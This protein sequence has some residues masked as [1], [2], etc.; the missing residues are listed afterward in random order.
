[1]NWRWSHG[2]PP[3]SVSSRCDS[4][5]VRRSPCFSINHQLKTETLRQ[6]LNRPLAPALSVISYK[7]CH[8]MLICLPC[9]QA[10][11]VVTL[12]PPRYLVPAHTQLCVWLSV[13]VV[14]HLYRRHIISCSRFNR[15]FRNLQKHPMIVCNRTPW[16]TLHWPLFLCCVQIFL[17]FCHVTFL[18]ISYIVDLYN[19]WF[20]LKKKLNKKK[21]AKK[22]IVDD[23]AE[24]GVKY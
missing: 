7:C 2:L 18:S 22:E 9:K 13:S 1:M 3:P 16:L 15:R 8:V 5:Y 4:T 20:C 21:N 19:I 17:L 6:R 14:C 11:S 12:L 10:R 23:T 24:R